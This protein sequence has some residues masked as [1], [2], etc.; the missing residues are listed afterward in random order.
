[1]Q[2][3]A[4]SIVN[5]MFDKV[6]LDLSNHKSDELSLSFETTGNF[7]KDESVY[8]LS[9]RVN[10]FN[11][12]QDEFPFVTVRC[13]GLFKFDNVSELNEI[14]DFF[15]RNAIAIL[16]PYVRA[17]ISLITS[18]ANLPGIILPTLNLSHLEVD[19]RKNTI[20]KK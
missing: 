8:E 9:F 1:M 10:V 14:P 6:S 18:Q 20:Q 3:A 4:F 7:I 17:Y 15:Y 11:E 5:F 13:V 19:L 12:N 16:F 2:T